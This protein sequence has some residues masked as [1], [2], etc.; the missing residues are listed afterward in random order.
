MSEEQFERAMNIIEPQAK[1][2]EPIKKKIRGPP[3][4]FPEPPA[5]LLK[6]LDIGDDKAVL[7]M[8]AMQK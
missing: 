8:V 7:E 2:L 4:T 1:A 6:P 5:H 3:P